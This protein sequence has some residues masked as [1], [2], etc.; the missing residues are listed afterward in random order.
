MQGEC[1]VASVPVL[2]EGHTAVVDEDRVCLARE[3]GA[4]TLSTYLGKQ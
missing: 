3:G 1:P 2:L 4:Q